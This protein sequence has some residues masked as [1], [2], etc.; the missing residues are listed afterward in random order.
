MRTTQLTDSVTQLTR[1][2]WVNCYLVREPDGFTLVDTTIPGASDDFIAAATDLGGTIR[3]IALT[4]AHTDHAGSLDLLREKLGAEVQVLIPEL[5]VRVLDGE[6]VWEGRKVKGG[7]PRLQT[8]PDAGLQGGEMV[9]S[10]EVIA[11]P[12]HTPGHVSFRDTRD[13]C[14]IA[15]DVVK[16][17]GGLAVTSHFDLRFPLPYLATWNPGR[18]VESAESLLELDLSWLAPGHGRA[19]PNPRVDLRRAVERARRKLS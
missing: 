11:T 18:D 16:T 10:L 3:R 9:G 14:L 1:Q 2:G 19:L 12:G 15:G 5:D 13:G 8:R 7:W 17:F 4:H 6:R